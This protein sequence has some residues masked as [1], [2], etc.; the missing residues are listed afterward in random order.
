VHCTALHHTAPRCTSLHHT[1]SHCTTTPHCTTLH[2]IAPHCTTLQHT[3]THLKNKDKASGDCPTCSNLFSSMR[4]LR[5]HPFDCLYRCDK[6]CLFL[7]RTHTICS[8]TLLPSL[9]LSLSSPLPLPLPL[10]LTLL[11][12]LPLPL[13]L[14]RSQSVSQSVFSHRVRPTICSFKAGTSTSVALLCHCILNQ[15]QTLAVE[16]T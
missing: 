5:T 16:F 10:P 8:S 14:P 12:P 13:L 2:H 4:T 3:A 6:L 7:S 9:P 1:A 15:E 11:L